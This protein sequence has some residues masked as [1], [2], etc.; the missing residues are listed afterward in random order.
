M[1]RL[2][3]RRLLAATYYVNVAGLGGAPSD[4]NTGSIDH[5]LATLL[6]ALDRAGPGDSIVLRGGTYSTANGNGP[7][8]FNKGGLPGEPLT[9]EA[10]PG[11]QPIIDLGQPVQW[12]SVSPGLWYGILPAATPLTDVPSSIAVQRTDGWTATAIP[13][14]AVDGGPPPDFTSP[15]SG[16]YQGG[17]LA[18]DLSWY[19][20]STRQIWLRSNQIEPI[21]NPDVQC[22]V[23]LV[24]VA[25]P[26]EQRVSGSTSTACR[27]RTAAAASTWSRK[28]TR[29]S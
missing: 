16:V 5:P 8:S 27:S 18:Y 22:E 1:E 9:I 23:V 15:P 21:T 4:N 24:H 2:E 10:Y 26:F 7:I 12:Q 14:G 3:P 19:N 17:Q 28:G 20:A 13:G 11:E 25:V 29:M 6:A